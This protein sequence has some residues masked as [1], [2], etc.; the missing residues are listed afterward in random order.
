VVLL[1]E[2]AKRRIDYGEQYKAFEN[3]QKKFEENEV[4]PRT[5]K[6]LLRSYRRILEYAFEILI[7]FT[8]GG[9]T[10]AVVFFVVNVLFHLE[11][12]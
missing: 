9:F 10:L 6:L 1:T 12:W 2:H 7:G 8:I 5:P 3:L 11:L 4:V